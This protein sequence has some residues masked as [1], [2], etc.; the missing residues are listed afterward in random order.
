MFDDEEKSNTLYTITTGEDEENQAKYE[1]AMKSAKSEKALGY[2]K[3][4]MEMKQSLLS[5]NE[6]IQFPVSTG[7]TSEVYK[8]QKTLY[9]NDFTTNNIMYVSE[10]DNIKSIEK[11]D[12][13]LVGAVKREDGTTTG[14]IQLFNSQK[15]ITIE[16][17]KKF[18]AVSRFIGQCIQNVE[19]LTKKLTQ[20]LAVTLDSGPAEN[21]VNITVNATDKIR[22]NWENIGKPLA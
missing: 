7:I 2:I 18:D 20:T 8:K 10:I 14:V 3:A 22:E 17:R 16:T 19:D 4:M 6:M 11:I 5:P 1:I 21:H 9:F 12:N 13:I 15:P